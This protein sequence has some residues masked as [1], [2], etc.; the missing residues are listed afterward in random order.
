MTRKGSKS[1]DEGQS[2]DRDAQRAR[3]IGD[4]ARCPLHDHL[5][6]KFDSSGVLVIKCRQSELVRVE[7][8]PA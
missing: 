6:G 8:R 3:I 4:E 1:S 7:G 2:D 5:L